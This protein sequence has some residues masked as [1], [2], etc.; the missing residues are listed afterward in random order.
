MLIAGIRV[1][2]DVERELAALEEH[3]GPGLERLDADLR[4]L[5]VA[6][7]ADVPPDLLGDLAHAC[8]SRRLV[9]RGAVREVDAED[10]G[11]CK[12]QLLHDGCVI[13]GWA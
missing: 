11:A 3:H 6:H 5:E 10:V 4:A 12:D 8:D 7:D 1:H 9:G 13:G 2:R